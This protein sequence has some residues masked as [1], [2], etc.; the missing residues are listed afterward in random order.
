MLNVTLIGQKCN[1]TQK[2]QIL[3]HY[4]QL[5]SHRQNKLIN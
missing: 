5:L 4:Q 3:R 1:S 2:N